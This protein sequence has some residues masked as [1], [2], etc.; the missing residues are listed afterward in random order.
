MTTPA[1]Q[2]TDGFESTGCN[3]GD[4]ERA[5]LSY[6]R[7][8]D[9]EKFVD[10][11]QLFAPAAEYRRPGYEPFIGRPALM[12]F[13]YRQRVITR[14]RHSISSLVVDHRTVAV[15]GRFT[16]ATRGGGSVNL[17]FADFFVLDSSGLFA[18]RETFFFVPSV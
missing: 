1:Q 4:A 17:R 12:D 7:L 5:V 9:D 11:I 15:R 14:G 18:A 3:R 8:V 2:V 10:L 6:Y 13:Y 16:G